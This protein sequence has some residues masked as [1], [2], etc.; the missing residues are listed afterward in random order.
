MQK[1]LTLTLSMT[2]FM[3]WLETKLVTE[4]H[5]KVFLR[6]TLDKLQAL[7]KRIK[8]TSREFTH[9]DVYFC[10]F[11]GRQP[12]VKSSAADFWYVHFSIPDIRFYV[13]QIMF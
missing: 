13:Y 5:S 9:G 1:L 10:S 3:K 2:Q 6:D 4:K 12:T 8:I 11:I 7:Y